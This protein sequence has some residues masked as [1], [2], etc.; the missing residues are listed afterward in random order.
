MILV[1]I[2]LY[3]SLGTLI[4]LAWH[5]KPTAETVDTFDADRFYRQEGD[6]PE[7]V[8]CIDDPQDALLRRI[9]LIESA[10]AEIFYCTYEFH[11][12]ESGKTVLAALLDA[13]DRGVRVRL[14]IDSLA[15]SF[16]VQ[17]SASFQALAAHERVEIRLYN[18]IRFHLPW[19]AQLRMHDK[20]I[21]IDRTTYLLGGRNTFDLFLGQGNGRKNID[22]ELLVDTDAPTGSASV[23]Q[24]T[25]YA[26]KI[27]WENCCKPF[28]RRKNAKTTAAEQALKA[29]YRDLP[30]EFHEP[31][32]RPE[33]AFTAGKITLLSGVTAPVNKEP[34]VWYAIQSLMRRGS[35][36]V[37]ET[38]YMILNKAM[39]RDLTAICRSA[40]NVDVLLNGAENGANPFGCTDYLNQKKKIRSIG[41]RVHEFYGDNSLHAKAVLIDHD[42]SL[43]GSFNMDMRSAYL[44]TE[45]MLAVDCPEL[46]ALLRRTAADRMQHSR[47]WQNGAYQNGKYLLKPKVSR[48]KKQIYRLLRIVIRPIRHLL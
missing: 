19:K 35:D 39:K 12:D 44:D 38:P 3:L 14:L 6:L 8:V 21:I 45:L 15:G 27:W 20:Y 46:N 40:Q 9:R 13:A 26:E 30:A 17:K 1:L 48:F 37:I 31:P 41:L 33:E 18:P 43:V 36:I 2:L 28:R 11:A 25:A 22:R 47:I 32:Y 4:P 29:R 5:K 24:L 42:L 10:K 16:S 34:V 23:R 7:Q